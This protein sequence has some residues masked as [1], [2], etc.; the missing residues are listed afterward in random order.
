MLGLSDVV[1]V[2][3]S[4][5]K[6]PYK[7][8][9]EHVVSREKIQD[10]FG[11]ISNPSQELLVQLSLRYSCPYAACFHGLALNNSACGQQDT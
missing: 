2:Q 11:K 3:L 4:Q 5:P 8:S 9:G 7:I 6:M 10:A 1:A